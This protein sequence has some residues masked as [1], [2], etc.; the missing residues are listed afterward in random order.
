MSTAFGIRQSLA[1]V[2]TSDSDLRHIMAAKWQSRGIVSGFRT[3]GRGNLTYSV[4][5]GL[6]I[7]GRDSTG[8]DGYVEAWWPGGSTPAVSANSGNSARHDAIWVCAHDIT[9]GDKDNLVTIG[10]TEDVD[11]HAIPA[12]ATRVFTMTMDA[13]ATTTQNAHVYESGK[14][15]VPFGASLGPIAWI[16]C[17][18]ASTNSTWIG[19]GQ[20]KTVCEGQFTVPTDRI[21]RAD[22]TVCCWAMNPTTINWLGSGYVDWLIDGKLVDTYRF[23]CYPQSTSC[24]TFCD[25][26][27]V[28]GGTHTAT[29]RI[30][31]SKIAPASGIWLDYGGTS[32][33]PGQRLALSDMGVDHTE[34]PAHMEQY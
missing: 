21:V 16:E 19:A 15:A 27:R 32:N 24:F 29:M 8:T 6:A 34:P 25:Y 3:S 20:S 14:Y 17:K 30:W 11:N 10:V 33:W 9:K 13:G 26:Q 31:G 18:Q 12:Y 7:C 22:L 23:V 1:G 2:G 4:G 5:A 28:K